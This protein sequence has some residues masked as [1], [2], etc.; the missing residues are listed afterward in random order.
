MIDDYCT[1]RPSEPM[2]KLSLGIQ[3]TLKG[4]GLCVTQAMT[5]SI[6]VDMCY[7]LSISQG[8]IE[9]D[10]TVYLRFRSIVNGNV[11]GRSDAGYRLNI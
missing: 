11:P 6:N 2:S 4:F 7:F 3:G 1:I 5:S 10:S 8:C 9:R